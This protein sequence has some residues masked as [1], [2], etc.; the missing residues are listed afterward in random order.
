MTAFHDVL[1]PVAVSFGS[2]GGPE[3][4][5]Q[6]VSLAGGHEERNALWA[7]SR[8]RWDAG[9]GLKSLDDVHALLAFFEARLGR[10]YAFRW[11]D[12][13][14]HKSCAPSAQPG[15]S[16]CRIGTGDGANA[17]F[18]LSKTY[19]SGPSA[20]QRPITK[21]TPGT[22]RVAVAGK[23]LPPSAVAVDPLSG[24]V[25]LAAPPPAGAPVTAGF[26]FDAPARFDTDRIEVNLAAFQAGEIPSAP[27]VEVRG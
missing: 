6:V 7:H 9:L 23:E 5:T 8:R 1:F 12:W 16:D 10:L 25:I 14:D 4:R 22:V 27:I 15:P 24:T 11:R 17:T 13:A 21:P 2:G 19:A 26:L 20:Y 3:R 18:Q